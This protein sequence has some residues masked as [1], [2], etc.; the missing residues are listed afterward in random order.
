MELY[1]VRNCTQFKKKLWH[2]TQSKFT[3]LI[4]YAKF[5]CIALGTLCEI[6]VPSMLSSCATHLGDGETCMLGTIYGM[7]FLVKNKQFFGFLSFG[8][9]VLYCA[10]KRYGFRE[11]K[12]F[13]RTDV[14]SVRSFSILNRMRFYVP[15]II[16]LEAVHWC[17]F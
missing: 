14:T 2:C 17:S 15:G 3:L 7:F 12:L 1:P 10:C 4:N 9:Q 11:W 6:L 16:M 8:C 5:F 13:V